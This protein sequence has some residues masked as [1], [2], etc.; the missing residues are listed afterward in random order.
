MKVSSVEMFQQFEPGRQ[1]SPEG[2]RQGRDR[3]ERATRDHD[4]IKIS[5]QARAL[6]NQETLTRSVLHAVGRRLLP[7]AAARDAI[8][9]IPD[10]APAARS[11]SRIASFERA[12]GERPAG[13]RRGLASKRAAE[14]IVAG[15]VGAIY[16]AYRRTLS[17]QRVEDIARFREEA[18]QGFEHGLTE[19]KHAL[20]GSE[21]LAHG[22]EEALE[23]TEA[24]VRAELDAFFARE[25]KHYA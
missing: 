12:S 3:E 22:L 9:S 23:E 20:A 21:E 18:L 25:S 6:A 1:D 10:P 5:G 13:S 24:I 2:D 16:N 11:N 14:R 4:D 19:A 17:G 8:D 7:A 15:I